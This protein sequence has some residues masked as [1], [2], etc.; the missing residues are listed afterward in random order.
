MLRPNKK[1]KYWYI[2]HSKDVNP[3]NGYEYHGNVYKNTISPELYYANNNTSTL[4]YLM[5]KL[6]NFI[7][8]EVKQIKLQFCIARDKQDTTIN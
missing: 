5:E 4:I 2:R 7:I 6:V 3:N 8:D 1:S